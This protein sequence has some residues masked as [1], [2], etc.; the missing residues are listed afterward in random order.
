MMTIVMMRMVMM[1]QLT[2]MFLLA[3]CQVFLLFFFYINGQLPD[4]FFMGQLPGMGRQIVPG[5][6]VGRAALH[7]YTNVTR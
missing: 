6:P 7:K 2:H 4:I 5:P 3:K 1:L